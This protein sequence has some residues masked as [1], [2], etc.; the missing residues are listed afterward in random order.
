M[1][2]KNPF[3]IDFEEYIRHIDSSK[4]EKTF[5]WSTAIG[6]QQVDGLKPSSYLYE[7]AKRN[8]EGELSFDDAKNLIDSYYECRTLRT[9]DEDERTEEADKVS[10]R[11][12]Q[13]LSEPSFNFSP[14][15]LIAIHKRLFEGIFKFAGKIRDYDITK[16]E[17]ALNGD[18]V[19]YGA[20]FELK[21]A[22]DYDFE[23]ERAFNYK[24]LSNDQIVK[25][26]TFFVSRLWQ[27]HAFGEGNTRTTAVF[28]IK[29]LRS[30]GYKA[31]ND[32]FAEN[33]WYFRNALV[34]ANYSNLQN[35]IQE[36]S[37]F[38]EL[39]FR[40]LILG[41]NNELKNRYTHV[42]YDSFARKFGD[43]S[44]ISEKKFGDN[45]KSSEIILELLKEDPKLSAKK[46]S[47]KIGIT[48]R[49]VE[50]QLASLVEKGFIKREG[51]PKSGHWEILK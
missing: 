1:A 33:S 5:A 13:I 24:G 49:A 29:Y 32:I 4:K 17:W 27:I 39:F 12:A 45:K 18:T 36:N 23:Q 22:L 40:N 41:E 6:L 16:K 50:K 2:E 46:L 15:H 47:E 8:I 43:N 30:L 34:R 9:E 3:E 48:S 26:I 38:L 51:S 11:I 25:H 21:S 44:E 31:D 10:T 14:S 19:M 7:T 42:D 35:G 28:T 20:S 37:E